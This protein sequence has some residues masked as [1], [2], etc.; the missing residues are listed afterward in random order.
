MPTALAAPIAG[1]LA[2]G[3]AGAGLGA[4]LSRGNQPGGQQGAAYV[5][6]GQPAADVNY[7]NLVSSFINPYMA[8]TTPA[9]INY[10]QAQG[11]ASGLVGSP[12]AGQALQGAGLASDIA[13]SALNPIATTN[14]TPL[15]GIAGGFPQA[16]QTAQ[17]QT[18]SSIPGLQQA[19]S[20]ILQ[21]A[22]DPQSALYMQLHQQAQQ[23]AQAANAAAGLGA[24]P[25]GAGLTGQALNN[26]DINWQ[27]QQLQR[28]IQG[29]QAAGGLGT[30][31]G[32]LAGAG[33]NQAITGARAMPQ[34]L[35]DITGLAGQMANLEAGAYGLPYQTL[36]GQTQ[37]GL[38]ALG[39]A[40]QLGQQQY[41]L[42]QQALQDLQSYLGLGQA[43]SSL[44][45]PQTQQQLGGLGAL[46]QAGGNLLF[47]SQG[48]GG[49]LGIN[50]QTGLLGSLF[51]GGNYANQ[52][53]Y[54]P[55]QGL[56]SPGAF[57]GE[58]GLFS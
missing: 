27:N 45:F 40:T 43:A 37:T 36:A 23:N 7:Q 51:G 55:T 11:L 56:Y 4:L 3:A 5:P 12:Y 24:S 42:P 21:Q 29:G 15:A 54:D 53:P 8:G 14:F 25:Y 46:G 58:P 28:M 44:A 57:Y 9:Q 39:G 38:G 52:I 31:I 35:G 41:T 30:T 10:P 26:L 16:G 33:L 13:Q 49:A 20:G 19:E 17:Q 1:G 48:L 50:P 22:F 47:G 6:Q 34:V 18:T 2:T 32:N